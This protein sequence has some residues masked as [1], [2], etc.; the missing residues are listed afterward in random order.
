MIKIVYIPNIGNYENIVV[1]EVFAIKNKKIKKNDKIITIEAGKTSLYINSPYTGKITE[2]NIKIGNNL[3]VGT[4]IIC[5]NVENFKNYMYIKKKN[6]TKTKNNN[7]FLKYN[8][9]KYIS[10]KFNMDISKI[11]KIK[12]KNDLRNITKIIKISECLNLISLNRNQKLSNKIIHNSWKKIPHV[13]QF[14]ELKITNLIKIYI[15]KKKEF[16]KQNISLTLLSIIIKSLTLT[17]I[18]NPYFNSSVYMND[19]ILIKKYYNIGIIMAIKNHIITPI[20][21]NVEKKNILEINSEI[22]SKKKLIKNY[23]LLPNDLE[24]GTFSISNLGN[25][26]DGFF[27]PIIKYPESAILGISKYKKSIF[28]KKKD[29]LM[30]VS[31]SY[32]HR[33]INGLD[34]VNFIRQ[35]QKELNEIIF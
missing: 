31:L 8:Y 29:F 35:F 34:A 5:I 15:E 32:D 4:P 12:Q 16:K 11:S 7:N 14:S 26:F 27:T 17:L 3:K 23:K 20:I 22:I 21:K 33:I 9:I 19:K 10:K 25:Y 6:I 13:T 24:N 18:K 2:I 30:P 28:K 1:T